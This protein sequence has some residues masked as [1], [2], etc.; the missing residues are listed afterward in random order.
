MTIRG[1]FG[2]STGRPYLRGRIALPRLGI[3]GEASFLLDTGADRTVLMPMDAARLGVD[4]AEL[5]EGAETLGVGG[6]SR[7][8]TEPALLGFAAED[9]TL[10]VYKI[11]LL[12]AAAASAAPDIPSLLGRNVLDRWRITYA[13]LEHTL[14]AAPLEFD[15]RYA[16]DG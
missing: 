15:A 5:S 2:D 10:F 4:Y 3:V 1:E 6:A 7:N 9:Q 11:S 16:P 8:F 14:S 12:V 13:P